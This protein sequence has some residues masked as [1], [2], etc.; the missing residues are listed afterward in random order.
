M[1][2][3]GEAQELVD[4]TSAGERLERGGFDRRSP[5]L[6]VRLRFTIYDPG[7]DAVAGELAGREEPGGPPPTMKTSSTTPPFFW[8]QMPAGRPTSFS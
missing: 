6:M 3:D 1:D 5:G 4:D 2:V 8:S 7:A